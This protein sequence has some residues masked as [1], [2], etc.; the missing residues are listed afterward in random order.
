MTT[1]CELSRRAARLRGDGG[2]EGNS[3]VGNRRYISDDGDGG[4]GRVALLRGI[5][6][7]VEGGTVAARR[8]MG[9]ERCFDRIVVLVN[10]VGDRIHRKR[11][12]QADERSS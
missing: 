5:D 1:D 3:N 9:A 8:T 2:A 6:Q 11:Q 10:D 12:Q 7:P 4:E